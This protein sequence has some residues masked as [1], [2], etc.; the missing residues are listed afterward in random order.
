MV[1]TIPCGLPEV[2]PILA[3][4]SVW[5]RGGNDV[6]A[7]VRLSCITSIAPPRYTAEGFYYSS[8]AGTVTVTP[9]MTVTP[10]QI[11]VTTAVVGSPSSTAV[12]DD[13]TTHVVKTATYGAS[14]FGP[15]IVGMFC[16]TNWNAAVPCASSPRFKDIVFAGA[17]VDGKP[18]ASFAPAGSRLAGV[19]FTVTPSALNAA[20]RAF[21]DT[22]R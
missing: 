10:G 5:D 22:Y 19:G 11:V 7:V 12:I 8:A 4:V 15:S 2:S 21:R 9:L 6:G 13:A 14:G 3:G 16:S 1:P 20:G 17:L 18:L